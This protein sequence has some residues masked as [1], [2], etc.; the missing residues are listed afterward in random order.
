MRSPGILESPP[1]HRVFAVAASFLCIVSLVQLPSALYRFF[2][3][4]AAPFLVVGISEQGIQIAPPESRG[5]DQPVRTG[6]ILLSIGGIAPDSTVFPES[7]VADVL[8]GMRIGD[9][10]HLDLLRE[11]KRIHAS[12]VLRGY[13]YG[14]CAGL[15]RVLVF[16]LCPP[17][18]MA[19]AL[20]VLFRRQRAR[21]A[22]LFFLWAAAL[23]VSFLSSPP[24][25]SV[26]PWWK[27]LR[28]VSLSLPLAAG[29]L[30]VPLLLHLFIVFPEERLFLRVPL[31]RHV[32]VY[33]VSL[34]LL[35]IAL[36][37]F[38][39]VLP[40]PVPAAKVARTVLAVGGSAAVFALVL[41]S[42]FRARSPLARR[43]AGALLLAFFFTVFAV[44][45]I[46]LTDEYSASWG[47][48]SFIRILV[49]A[50]A[51]LT[52][53]S[54]LPGALGHGL[55]RYGFHDGGGILRP[56]ALCSA[57]VFTAAMFVGAYMFFASFPDD[58]DPLEALL[59]SA[60]PIGAVA[61]LSSLFIARPG[62]GPL[63]FP[64]S[65]KRHDVVL[66]SLTED[67]E[68]TLDR[69]RLLELLAERLPS[70]LGTRASVCS[71]DAQGEVNLL[72]GESVSPAHMAALFRRAD[73][74]KRISG[75][76][77]LLPNTIPGVPFNEDIGV[78]FPLASREEESVLVVLAER[79]NG[80][81]YT[82]REIAHLRILAEQAARSWKNTAL[83]DEIRVQERAQQQREIVR[84]MRA[85]APPPTAESIAGM[86]GAADTIHARDAGGD[87][88]DFFPTPEG[89]HA[90]V[91]GDVSARGVAGAMLMAAAMTAIRQTVEEGGRTCDVLARV[92]K[93]LVSLT[94]A[95]NNTA[96][97]LGVYEPAERM[98]RF[99][100]GGLPKPLLIRG[101]E[102]YEIDWSESGR[103]LP[104]GMRPDAAFS[105]QE[106]PV[107]GGDILV[108]YTDGVV[109]V[110][111]VHAEPFGVK[112]LR[113]AVLASSDASAL[114][115]VRH[116]LEA[117]RTFAGKNEPHDDLTLLVVKF[118]PT[119]ST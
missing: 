111:D 54:A 35:F 11:G 112:R 1:V 93:R 92:N 22:S 14:E 51:V 115:I 79:P 18:L 113:D 114:D 4:P 45:L 70:H 12:I 32:V 98:L 118:P 55:L 95:P 67:L 82:V 105:E 109:D 16:A 94:R 21:E 71:I 10:L 75:G 27:A 101:R 87:F 6:D 56:P 66:Q 81:P 86:Q 90:F 61:T 74:S 46:L 89:L 73:F 72:A 3:R 42:R 49:L 62:T 60:V 100:N 88:H 68:E 30:A 91:L 77:I 41:D 85:F 9:T 59:M 84:T 76:E 39:I 108:L 96:V 34:L 80:K 23:A 63:G 44:S 50:I 43:V 78:V 20:T 2:T 64:R 106:L 15:A 104:L 26:L 102:S 69:G 58:F 57:M 65:R 38:P 110:S 31:L 103:R 97:F 17:V 29:G 5:D 47:I 7:T 99:T 19:I 52:V 25:G 53:V 117:A 24:F 40:G 116:A 33:G 119:A 83:A 107:E 8:N 37:L 28:P 48:P 36:P 13:A